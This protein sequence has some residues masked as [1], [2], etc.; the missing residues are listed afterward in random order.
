MYYIIYISI[1]CYSNLY[2]PPIYVASNIM[3]MLD[4]KSH[5]LLTIK[6]IIIIVLN[7]HFMYIM[8]Y[9]HHHIPN[10]N[11]IFKQH[12]SIHNIISCVSLRGVHACNTVN[13]PPSQW[14][15]LT[16]LIL[17]IRSPLCAVTK[18]YVWH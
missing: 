3:K 9:S 11:N 4:Y 1:D 13:L 7:I 17:S 5:A 10:L 12:L 15:L 18:K 16:S 8:M 14:I 6:R 2:I